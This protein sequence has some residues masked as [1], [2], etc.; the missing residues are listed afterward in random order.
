MISKIH[1]EIII[2]RSKDVLLMS[3]L[4]S[5]DIYLNFFFQFLSPINR[6]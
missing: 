2:N 3:M 1:I 6:R 4:R 5:Y